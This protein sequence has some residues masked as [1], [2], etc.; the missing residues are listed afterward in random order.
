MLPY[1]LDSMTQLA[2]VLALDHIDEM[3]RRVAHLVEER[4][5]VEAALA[6]MAVDVW[7]S[8]AN[9]ILLRPWDRDGDDVWQEM[10]DRSVLVRNCSS[11][12]GLEG[13]LRVTL[14]TAAED[15]EFLVALGEA[16]A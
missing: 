4:G 11:W 8:A 2:G 16:L 12:P 10:V 7:P 5:R 6:D 9:F 3:R 15:D 1:H 14:G 13:C